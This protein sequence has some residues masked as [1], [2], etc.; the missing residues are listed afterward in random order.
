MFTDNMPSTTRH[1]SALTTFIMKSAPL[2][3]TCSMLGLFATSYVF[4][5]KS[6]DI[7]QQALSLAKKDPQVIII[8]G[9]NIKDAVFNSSNIARGLATFKISVSGTLGQGLLIVNGKRKNGEWVMERVT[10][11]SDLLEQQLL[12]YSVSNK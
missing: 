2:L 1:T 4:I 5:P 9:E 3:I 6:Y 10:F 7:Y 11:E 8:L 12:L